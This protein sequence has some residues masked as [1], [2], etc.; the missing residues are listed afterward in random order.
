[1]A[2]PAPT[3][4]PGRPMTR[5]D[6]V[7]LGQAG[8][9]WDF[10]PLGVQALRQLSADAV[11][12]FLVTANLAQLGLKT[13]AVETLADLPEAAR[14]ERDVRALAEAI[15]RLPDDRVGAGERRRVALGNLRALRARQFDRG[16]AIG[17]AFERWSEGLE[18][19]ECFRAA[20]GNLVRRLGRD[21]SVDWARCLVD[22]RGAAARRC[23]C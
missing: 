20:D 17:E 13:L 6:V 23:G 16:G 2:P 3:Q 19:D 8:R 4:Q 11:V 12:R 5:A 14:G 22:Q 21:A 15:E 7:A 1:M 10:L 18:A 9:P